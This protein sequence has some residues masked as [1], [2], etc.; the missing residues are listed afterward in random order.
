MGKLNRRKDC[1]YGTIIKDGEVLLI[2][3]QKK[4]PQVAWNRG[5]TKETDERVAQYGRTAKEN[6][7]HLGT[8]AWND[9]IKTGPQSPE[10]IQKRIDARAGYHPSE[11]VKAQIKET[12]LQTWSSEELRLS[13]SV[14][15]KDG[16]VKE[17][18]RN[19]DRKRGFH[20]K[21]TEESNEKNR[22]SH[23]GRKRTAESLEKAKA[24]VAAKGGPPS[25]PISPPQPCACGCLKMTNPGYRYVK[26]HATKGKGIVKVPQLCACGCL[27]MTKPG[28]KYIRGHQCIGKT[29]KVSWSKGLTKETDPRLAQMS[30]DMKGKPGHPMPQEAI[31]IIRAK[32]TEIWKQPGYRENISQSISGINH[33]FYRNRPG[34]TPDDFS[35]DY[36]LSWTDQFKEAVRERDGHKCKVC[37]KTEEENG[38][39]LDVHHIDYDR[40][41]L[42]PNNLVSL[43][44]S[45]H[46]KTV[47]HREKWT[48]FFLGPQRIEL[49]RKQQASS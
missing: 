9:G 1:E 33:P 7:S 13:H 41:N 36:P 22:Q 14:K 44:K 23:L 3:S 24:T 5:L 20:G 35:R 6:G 19:P 30:E 40:E 17:K 8:T 47:T 18:E 11:D 27:G 38:T 42:D 12:N 21:H 32:V 48:S 43:C 28:N 26:G 10:V 46:G 31:E 15:V 45:C 39:R 49:R 16:L 37:S 4:T 34:L 2:E 29:G 25:K